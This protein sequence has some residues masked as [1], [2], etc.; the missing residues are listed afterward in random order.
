MSRLAV[1]A[2]RPLTLVV[3]ATSGLFLSVATWR[4]RWISAGGFRSAWSPRPRPAR[5]VVEVPYVF[6]IELRGEQDEPEKRS[7]TSRS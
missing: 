1:A 6:R 7:A 5:T 3:D 2:A 4:G